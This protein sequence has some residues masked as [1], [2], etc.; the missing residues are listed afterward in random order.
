M[1]AMELSRILKEVLASPTHVLALLAAIGAVS[2]AIVQFLKDALRLRRFWNRSWLLRHLKASTSSGQLQSDSDTPLPG[3]SAQSL[4]EQIAQDPA[5]AVNDIIHALS[6]LKP[7]FRYLSGS[8]A[9]TLFYALWIMPESWS[10]WFKKGLISP[11][12]EN[13]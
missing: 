4:L 11:P 2:S 13:V 9:K 3:I 5:K 6:A 10:H 8:A 12:P 1:D 7:K